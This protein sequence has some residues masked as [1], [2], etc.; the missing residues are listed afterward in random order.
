MSHVEVLLALK[1]FPDNPTFQPVLTLF[2]EHALGLSLLQDNDGRW[3]QV[4]DAPTTF[5]ETSSTAMTLWSVITGVQEKWLDKATFSPIIEKAWQGLQKAIQS[6]GIVTGICE[7]TGVGPNVDWY[8]QRSTD[9]TKSSP[10]LGSV[11]RAIAA[12]ERYSKNK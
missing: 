11:L 12:Y 10:G 2:Q 4:L 1:N 7:G 8:N 3:H 9:Y 6:D 5:L